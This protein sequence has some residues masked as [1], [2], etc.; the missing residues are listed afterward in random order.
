M[1]LNGHVEQP[2]LGIH[3]LRW[4]GLNL[5]GLGSTVAEKELIIRPPNG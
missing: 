1:L 5:R 2:Q 4:S 3:F